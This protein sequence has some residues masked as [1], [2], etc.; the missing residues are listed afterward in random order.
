MTF[1]WRYSRPFFSQSDNIL[2]IFSPLFFS[3]PFLFSIIFNY[4]HV[5]RKPRFSRP[6]FLS[7]SMFLCCSPWLCVLLVLYYSIEEKKRRKE[8][9]G[10]RGQRVNPIKT[11]FQ[12]K[13]SQHTKYHKLMPVEIEIYLLRRSPEAVLVEQD[14]NRVSDGIHGQSFYST[15][16]RLRKS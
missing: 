8:A 4:F 12:I 9:R 5:R 1:F 15:D 7:F 13:K 16:W 11:S 14:Q 3:D 6:I 2:T 10:K